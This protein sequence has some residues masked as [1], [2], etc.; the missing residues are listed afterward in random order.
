MNN[1]RYSIPVSLAIWTFV[2]MNNYAFAQIGFRTDLAGEHEVPPIF[3]ESYG[4][5]LVGGNDDNLKYQINVTSL[6]KVTG[7]FLYKGD[8]TENGQILVSLLNSTDPSG[9]ID[10]NL[11]EGTINSSSILLPLANL[12]TNITLAVP[13]SAN[14][15]NATAA[16]VG[17]LT[18]ATS[19]VN[20]SS[21]LEALIDL[22]GQNMT[23]INILTSDFPQG[24][25]R[26]TLTS[27]NST[28]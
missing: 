16:S 9:V 28:G 17:N 26:G 4:S 2:L 21:K 11:I 1:L 25:L 6:D 24:E 7:A 10:G 18:N 12:T 15:T 22:M 13:A 14:L 5:A 23:Y 20:T 27:T 3:S 19:S 8:S